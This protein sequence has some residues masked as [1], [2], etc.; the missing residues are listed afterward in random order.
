MLL[1]LAVSWSYAQERDTTQHGEELL[2]ASDLFKKSDEERRLMLLKPRFRYINMED[3]RSLIKIG[4]RPDFGFLSPTGNR[5]AVANNLG[6]A[7]ERKI[8]DSPFSWT[9]ETVARIHKADLDEFHY[10]IRPTVSREGVLDGSWIAN[11]EFFAHRFRVHA[12][13]RYY[14]NF[15]KRQEAEVTGHN[16]ASEYFL[17][18]LRDVLAYTEINEFDFTTDRQLSLHI[19]KKKWLA[20]PAYFSVGVGIQ[21][22]FLNKFLVDLNVAAGK[23]LPFGDSSFEFV[24][25]DVALDINLFIGLG[26]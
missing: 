6:F 24:H 2:L 26:L 1:L 7:Y 22:P 20:R 14:F 8:K 13:L 18:R 12:A 9:I 16:L 23:R 3:K 19:R 25:K 15:R 5:L 21:R 11:G 17:F 10:K 4:Y